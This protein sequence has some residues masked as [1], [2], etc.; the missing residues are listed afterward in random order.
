MAQ[1]GTDLTELPVIFD[2]ERAVPLGDVI[3]AYDVCRL[4]GYRKLQFAAQAQ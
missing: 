3:E 4:E 1:L 2:I